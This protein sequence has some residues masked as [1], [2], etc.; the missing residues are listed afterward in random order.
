MRALFA[1]HK[2]VEGLGPL[3]TPFDEVLEAADVITLHCPLMLATRNMIAA[4]EFAKMKKQ[5][6]LINCS[7]GGVVNEV[8]LVDALDR[9]Q[10]AGVGFD[11]PTSEPPTPDN[12]LLK[13]IDRPNVII[14]PH[15]AWASDEAM[16]MLWKQV[17]Q[18]IGNFHAGQP[19]NQIA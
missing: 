19:S 8:D 17:V 16:Q 2:N 1:A 4:P 9:G 7:R 12:P 5:P 6:L 10:I 11:C 18:H 15:V 14:T 3:Y 13:I